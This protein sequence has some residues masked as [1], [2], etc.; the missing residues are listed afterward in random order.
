MKKLKVLIVD[1][2]ETILLFE[3]MMLGRLGYEIVMARNGQEALDV[4]LR[5]SLDLILLD[6][7]MPVMDGLEACR[8][9]KSNPQTQNIPVIM[10]TT[11]GEQ[12]MIDEA[13]K[14]GCN[15]YT[16]K[17]IDTLTLLAVIKKVVTKF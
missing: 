12:S 9:L 8:R 14:A 2:T 13:F 17:P 5:D 1:D 15:E 6:I 7:M 16:T 11:K 4:A 3:K 10:V